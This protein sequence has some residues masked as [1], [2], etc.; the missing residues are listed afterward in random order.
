MAIKSLSHSSL[1]DNR[2]YRSMLVGNEAYSPVF[3]GPAYDL[4]ET[5]SITGDTASVT[6][7]SGGVWADYRHLI[8]RIVAN[9]DRPAPNGTSSAITMTFNNDS[10][11]NYHR[12]FFGAYGNST[13]FAGGNSPRNFIDLERYGGASTP[14]YEYG[15]IIATIAEINNT[16]KWKNARHYGAIVRDAVPSQINVQGAVWQNT[17]AITRLDFQDATGA[18]F[19]AG[20][21]INLY[22]LKG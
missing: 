7:T 18:N 10:G 4:I 17:S 2:F 22:G 21:E 5:A 9:S 6:F 15:Q 3:Y 13:P 16:N 12:Q 8:L 11:A 14:A 1:T 19:I 20:S